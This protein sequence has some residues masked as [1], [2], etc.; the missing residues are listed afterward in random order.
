MVFEMKANQGGLI[1]YGTISM[2]EMD[3]SMSTLAIYY[4]YSK[5]HVCFTLNQN[6][7]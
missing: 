3:I 5:K 7:K 4:L 2:W 1:N 6:L